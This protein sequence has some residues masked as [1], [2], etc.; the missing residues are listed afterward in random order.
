MSYVS[1]YSGLDIN[2][3]L[4][5]GVDGF[6][7]T[8]KNDQLFSY[9]GQTALVVARSLLSTEI[10]KML[11]PLSNSNKFSPYSVCSNIMSNISLESI[12]GRNIDKT[13]VSSLIYNEF[14]KI[15]IEIE[16]QADTTT[17]DKVMKVLDPTIDI[18]STLLSRV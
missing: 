12:S 3:V 8:L 2:P 13:L 4:C 11:Q 5:R 16:S 17:L 14:Y 10:M 15:S 9:S 7:N 1:G 18:I 6:N